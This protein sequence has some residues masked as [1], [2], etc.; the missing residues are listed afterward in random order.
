MAESVRLSLFGSK[1]CIDI[2]IILLH[3]TPSAPNSKKLLQR[4][5]NKK[6]IPIENTAE[7]CDKIDSIKNDRMYGKKY[8]DSCSHCDTCQLVALQIALQIN[9]QFTALLHPKIICGCV[10]CIPSTLQFLGLD[11]GLD[12]LHRG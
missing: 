7:I 3:M 5:D 6:Q 2:H 1:K 11:R 10:K 12:S 9:S 8:L 4:N